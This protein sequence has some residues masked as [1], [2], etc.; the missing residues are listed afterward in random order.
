MLS[1]E[2]D[3]VYFEEDLQHR[4]A[5]A[6]EDV[7]L[8]NFDEEGFLSIAVG[9]VLLVPNDSTIFLLFFVD[10]AQDFLQTVAVVEVGVDKVHFHFLLILLSFV[11]PL[12]LI[13]AEVEVPP[14]A[15]VGLPSE[16]LL[17]NFSQPEV[18]EDG[19]VPLAADA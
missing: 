12:H 4:K 8:E 15:E 1:V 2:S 6:D 5:V 10:L 13:T 16:L 18:D 9:K 14:E 7:E 11:E 17:D 19:P 3:F